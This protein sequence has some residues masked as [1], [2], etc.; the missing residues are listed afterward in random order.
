M[1]ITATQYI[2]IRLT[3]NPGNNEPDDFRSIISACIKEAVKPGFKNMFSDN[4]KRLL[5][6]IGKGLNMKVD[7]ALLI[8][9]A[10]DTH[11]AVNFNE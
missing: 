6:N 1:E 2:D 8:T 3:N 5:A 9:L 11:T 7:D 4:E 10:A